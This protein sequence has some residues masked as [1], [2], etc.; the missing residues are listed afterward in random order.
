[1]NLH[2]RQHW[3]LLSLITCFLKAV[4][5]PKSPYGNIYRGRMAKAANECLMLWEPAIVD[6]R[7]KFLF[8]RWWWEKG[9]NVWV[10]AMFSF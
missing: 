3:F 5:K 6:L 4:L 2:L 1:M 10:V 7:R 8:S 9:T